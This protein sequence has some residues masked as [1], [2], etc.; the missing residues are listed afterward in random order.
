MSPVGPALRA[1]VCST[2]VCCVSALIGQDDNERAVDSLRIVL[3]SAP[4]D[5]DSLRI[6]I[7]LAPLLHGPARKQEAMR[8]LVLADR[9]VLRYP[10]DKERFTRSQ[11]HACSN[12]GSGY[13][14]MNMGDSALHYWEMGLGYASTVGDRSVEAAIRNGM[15]VLAYQQGDMDK[16]VGLM[17]QGLAIRLEIGDTADLA[18]SYTNLA[19]MEHMQGNVPQALEYYG[20]ALRKAERDTDEEVMS[21]LY[22]NIGALHETQGE[23]DS[24]LAAYRKAVPLLKKLKGN[25]AL[26]FAY[27]NMATVLL[28]KHDLDGAEE[29]VREGLGEA[30]KEHQYN[31]LNDLYF[32]LSRIHEE[33][34]QWDQAQ[35]ACSLSLAYAD[36]GGYVRGMAYAH[37]Q[38]AR[39]EWLR[40]RPAEALREAKLSVERAGGYQELNL[41]K[42]RAEL[43]AEIYADLGDHRNAYLQYRTYRSLSDSLTNEKNRKDLIRKGF[44]YEYEKRAAVLQAEREKEEELAAKEIEKQKVIRN[45]YA[46][47]G[48]LALLLLI[49][50]Y[51]RY[52]F[53]QQVNDRLEKQ[54]QIIL[55]EKKRSDELLLNILP[56]EVAEELK[57][58]GA[59]QAKHFDTATIL[60]SDFKGF[61]EASEKLT[62][63]ELVEELNVCFKA[64][65]HITAAR[66]IEKIKTIGDAY[67]CAGGLPDPKSSSPA[68]VVEAALEMQAFMKTRKAERDAQGKPAF[69]MRVGIHTGPVV[70]G[71][72][73][74][75]KFQY[76]I[77][78]DT[79]NTASRMES[80]GEP[81]QV[82]ISEATYDLVKDQPG[83]YFT[84]RGKVVAKGKGEMEMF[85]VHHSSGGA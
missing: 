13:R 9:C 34:R 43:L 4:S 60:F 83:L 74:V 68:D 1:M 67:M 30:L 47:S 73:G 20:L 51:R 16:A 79:V 63:Q 18:T 2:L 24:A 82:N 14:M 46:A 42:D 21:A 35:D 52:R 48:A 77:W 75:K 85:F 40:G 70:A 36:S 7:D 44:Q 11:A 56:E 71:I 58:T 54:N 33:R 49:G 50:L 10:R 62:P 6:M 12:L 78:G 28:T 27:S 23:L 15:G 76:D 69:E 29:K 64:F 19:A 31:A 81:G 45:A 39:I 57:D 61:T 22:V 80:S 84:S 72:V 41:K 66:G 26:A 8:A 25:D 3:R 53:K 32:K 5:T 38:M 59:A 37:V 55:E 17:K 65:D